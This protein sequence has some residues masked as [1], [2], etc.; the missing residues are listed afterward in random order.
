MFSGF[1]KVIRLANLGKKHDMQGV[2]LL[3]GWLGPCPAGHAL[4][5]CSLS[6]GVCFVLSQLQ[7]LE[8]DGWARC[9]LFK[10]RYRGRYD[11]SHQTGTTYTDGDLGMYG[12][13]N[14]IIETPCNRVPERQKAGNRRWGRKLTP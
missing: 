4:A 14:A 2:F 11:L 13:N 3:G 5:G 10:K 12:A 8:R 6:L 7:T 1:G 9:R